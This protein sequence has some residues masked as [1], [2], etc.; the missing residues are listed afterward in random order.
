VLLAEISSVIARE[1]G[2]KLFQVEAT[3]KLLDDSNT[4]PFIAR[5]RKEATGELDEEQIRAVEDRTSYLRNLVKRQ[6]EILATITEQGKLTPELEAAIL[7]TTKLQELEDLYLPFRPKKRTRAQIARERGLEPLAELIVAQQLSAGDPLAIAAEYINQEKEVSTAE[8]AIAGALDII[9]ETVSERADIRAMLRKQLWAGGEIATE[10]A[11]PEAAGQEFLNYRDHRELVKRMPS[12]RVL[13][14]N[15]G[16]RK[17]VLKVQLVTP[18]E[19]NIDLIKRQIVRPPSIF[20]DLIRQAVGDGYKRLLFPSLEREIRGQLTENAEQQA[21][22]VFGLNLRQ[23]LLQPPFAGHTVMG[24]D[25]GYRTGCKLAIISPTGAVLTT[26]TIY[27]TASEAQRDQATRSV[28]A[29]IEKHGVTL[30]SIGNGTASYETE[31]FVAKLISAHNLAVRYLIVNE[32]G[33]SVYSASKLAKDELPGLDVTLRGAVSIAR[34]IEDPLAELVKIDPKSIGVGQYQH[35]VDQK[36]LGRTLANI[37]ESCVNHVGVELNTAS[38]ELL[39][40]VA[41]V[42]NTVAKN[43]I[44]FRDAG[45]PFVNRQQLLKV[46]RLGA[47]TFTQC[48]GFLRLASGENPLDNT[49]VHPE[50]YQLAKTVLA[51]LGFSLTDLTDKDRLRD[52]QAAIQAADA[53]A[54]AAELAAGEPTVR[55]I[56]GA[57]AKPGRDP[58]EDMPQPLTRKNIVKLSDITP[59]TVMKGT[60]HNVTD[61]GV[62]VD[63][64]IKTNGL[65]HRSELSDKPFRHPLDILSVG[66]IIDCLILSVDENRGRIALSLKKVKQQQ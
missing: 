4:V 28:L 34:R 59:G 22:R 54:L 32:A 58:R 25:P 43:I 53:A 20:S 60:V 47:A 48:A 26:N 23:L 33:A 41:G 44:A 61:F 3:V 13:A 64:G 50:S 8:A 24:L 31:E 29:A 5:Y 1:L 36:E 51:R 62:F 9:A 38:A 65:I 52:L 40:Y 46:P 45:G 56:L 7:A 27:I 18:H 14:V 10:L 2:L 57:L 35:D 30:I 42:N 19:T 55:D 6:E 63:I 11:V 37:V 12:H 15:R 49:P 16:E 21:I 17:E 66:D 39:T